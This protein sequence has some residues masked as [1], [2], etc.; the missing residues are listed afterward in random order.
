MKYILRVLIVLGLV[1][2]G[3]YGYAMDPRLYN[4]KKRMLLLKEEQEKK[5]AL[6]KAEQLKKTA[7]VELPFA[8][9]PINLHLKN[10]L[11]TA[12]NNGTIII[13]SDMFTVLESCPKTSKALNDAIQNFNVKLL[14]NQF[15]STDKS[16]FDS[17]QK[18]RNELKAAA[19]ACDAELNQQAGK[20][21]AITA[22]E[23][24]WQFSNQTAKLVTVLISISPES[25][26]QIIINPGDDYGPLNPPKQP[27]MYLYTQADSYHLTIDANSNL[28][29]A[30][31]ADLGQGRYGYKVFKTIPFQEAND[32]LFIIN[33]DGSVD[34]VKR[35]R[36]K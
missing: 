3:Y 7:S 29:L 36:S 24:Q 21:N 19:L 12:S 17:Y 4:L 8:D 14:I 22:V 6:L 1:V 25:W 16:S 10:L 23:K 9:L 30:K 28:T 32:V 27:N 13:S 15:A 35:G 31:E 34:F 20:I 11:L 26:Q 18:A 33:P 2:Q 5:A